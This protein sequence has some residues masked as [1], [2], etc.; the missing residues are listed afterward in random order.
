MRYR[1][2]TMSLLGALLCQASDS[3]A[4]GDFIRE[5][6]FGKYRAE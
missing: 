3:V 1:H 6:F 5:D 2:L 4:G